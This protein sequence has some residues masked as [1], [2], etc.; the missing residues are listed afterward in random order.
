MRY[1][2][3]NEIEDIHQ[4]RAEGWMIKDI[5]RRFAVCPDTISHHISGKTVLRGMRK[6]RGEPKLVPVAEEAPQ[7][8][9]EEV[10][11]TLPDHVLFEHVRECNFIG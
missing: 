2:A 3:K 5:A 4:L 9:K 6:W 7:K 10:F 11:S 1:L 8:V